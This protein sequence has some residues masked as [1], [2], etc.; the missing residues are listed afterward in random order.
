[1]GNKYCVSTQIHVSS[2]ISL[3]NFHSRSN[4][5]D[6][7]WETTVECSIKVFSPPQKVSSVVNVK[8]KRR[9]VIFGEKLES[10]R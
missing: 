4:S 10:T 7:T 3:E 2:P 6:A 1:M 5:F 8:H 9:E